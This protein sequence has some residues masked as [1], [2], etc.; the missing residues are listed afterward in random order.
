MLPYYTDEQRRRGAETRRRRSLE[1]KVAE[2]PD[3]YYDIYGWD[4]PRIGKEP[5]LE[6]FGLPEDIE[7]RII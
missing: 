7:E 6:D 1:R 3:D 2:H 5:T 4:I